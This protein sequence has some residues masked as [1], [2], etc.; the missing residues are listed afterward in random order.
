MYLFVRSVDLRRLFI[1]SGFPT[2]LAFFLFSTSTCCHVYAS[3]LSGSGAVLADYTFS[4]KPQFPT[5]QLVDE[6]REAASTSQKSVFVYHLYGHSVPFL[7]ITTANSYT[8]RNQ[9]R[10]PDG[11]KVLKIGNNGKCDNKNTARTAKLQFEVYSPCLVLELVVNAHSGERRA[12][13]LNKLRRKCL[14]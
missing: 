7:V 12:T 10:V 6:A 4:W 9:F 3:E 2:C 14:I 5:N 11:H 13:G 1:R 8:H